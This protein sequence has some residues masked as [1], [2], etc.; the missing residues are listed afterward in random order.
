MA[1]TSKYWHPVTLPPA[2]DGPFSLDKLR[3]V[4]LLGRL[5]SWLL[6]RFSLRLQRLLQIFFPVLRVG[7]FVCLTRA[8]DIE[9]V[10]QN[11]QDF[12]VPFGPEMAILAKGK[13]FVLGLDG[14]NHDKQAAIIKAL[15]QPSDL[16]AITDRTRNMTIALLDAG[17]GTID[18]QHDLVRRTAAEG[19]LAWFGLEADDADDFADWATACSALLF[20]NPTGD[21]GVFALARDGARRICA[22]IDSAIERELAIGQNGTTQPVTLAARLASLLRGATVDRDEIRAILLGL[23]VGFVPTNSMAGGKILLGLQQRPEALTLARQAVTTAPDEAK[24]R[25]IIRELARLAPAIAPGVWRICPKDAEVRRNG[26]SPIRIT[27]GTT[28]LLATEI[29][30]RDPCRTKQPNRFIPDRTDAPPFVFGD[31]PHRCLGEQAALAHLTGLLQGLLAREGVAEGL[32]AMAMEWLGPFPDRAVIHYD[33]G[34]RRQ[35]AL[36]SVIPLETGSID[37]VNRELDR[38]SPDFEQVKA[39]LDAA[40]LIHFCSLAAIDIAEPGK[41]AEPHLLVEINFDGD[42]ADAIKSFAGATADWLSPILG[43]S[44]LRDA[45]S[46]AALV[47]AHREPLTGSPWGSTALQYFGRQDLPAWLIDRENKLSAMAREAVDGYTRDNLGRSAS[48]HAVLRSV[49]KTIAASGYGDNGLAGM[50]LKPGR[51]VLELT[52]WKEPSSSVVMSELLRT[53]PMIG[54]LTVFVLAAAGLALLMT[55]TIDQHSLGALGTIVMA[56]WLLLEGAVYTAL[57]FA[58]I[59]GGFV[60]LLRRAED[61]D[62]EDRSLPALDH[63]REIAKHEDRADCVQNH[64]LVV[65]RIKPGLLRRLVLALA[66]WGIGISVRYWFRPGFVVSMGSIHFARWVRL[67]KRDIMIFQSNYD[68]S[69][70]SYLEDFITR[71]HWG[72]TA[73][74]SNAVGFPR[75]RYLIYDGA[76]NGDAFKHYVRTRQQ[77]TRFWFSRFPT[78]TNERMR[79]NVLIHDGL[80]RARGE[81]EAKAWLGLFD[82]DQAREQT[83]EADE[84]QSL[85]FSGFGRLTQAACLTVR[86]EGD[87]EH[88]RDWLH[89][90]SGWDLPPESL[91]PSLREVETSEWHKLGLAGDAPSARISFGEDEFRV[92][93]LAA[94]L[95]ANGLTKLQTGR[96]EAETLL[97]AFPPAFRMGMAARSDK[98]GD[99]G[100]DS[101]G[102]WSWSDIPAQERESL[103]KIIGENYNKDQY[104]IDGMLCCYAADPQTLAWLVAVHLAWAHR[105]EINLDAIAP[106]LPLDKDGLS[107]EPFGFRDGLVQPVIAGSRK[108]ARARPAQ[109]VIAPGEMILGYPN[110]QGFPTPSIAVPARMDPR[111]LLPS[112]P[113]AASRFPAFGSTPDGN[114]DRD[115]GRNGTFLAV[116]WL[117]Q[118][119]TAFRKKTA[120]AAT[121]IA[122]DYPFAARLFGHRLDAEWVAAKMVGRWPNGAPLVGNPVPPPDADVESLVDDVPLMFGLRD[123]EGLECPLGAHIRRANPRD[124]LEPGDPLEVAIVNRHRLIRRGRSYRKADGETGLLFLAICEDLERQFEFV[125]RTWLGSPSFQSLSGERDPLTGPCDPNTSFTIPTASGPIRAKGLGQFVTVKGGGYFFLPSRAALLYLCR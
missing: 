19:C 82:S 111:A 67:K 116:R 44:S 57:G 2:W 47:K 123:P 120:E 118:D 48:A 104:T 50:L 8:D 33:S 99:A 9:A 77:P 38:I 49:R 10:L 90:V 37:S 46:L 29:G 5:A 56:F 31:H 66:L 14:G 25:A 78:L 61:S 107:R 114:D 102:S 85:V 75:S 43:K 87:A 121:S 28:L 3:P 13:S 54:L 115:F 40:G 83:V 76:A 60:W 1:W 88:A 55:R 108:A 4:G 52:A 53:P 70:E 58:A 7:Q 93:A 91:I 30:L 79:R 26:K 63:L 27:G 59:V 62:P 112:I 103:H 24:L 39:R 36:I 100:D 124:S 65:T 86:I 125:Q 51:G 6:R 35:D 94:A 81:T 110:A 20:G 106:M 84:V 119:V 22:L 98:L 117:K 95:S 73:A 18:V 122:R 71:A 17:G 68:G 34:P 42:A 101:A 41:P 21:Q 69:W 97:D 74:W 23:V 109:D 72:Q 45:K 89:G 80:A 113:R 92:V 96:D 105:H 64:I 11:P 12:P 15:F 32:R 16:T